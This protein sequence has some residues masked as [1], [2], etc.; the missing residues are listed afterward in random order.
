MKRIMAIVPTELLDSLER[1]LRHCGVPGVT[2]EHVQGY[3]HHPNY[4]RRD[5]L[6]N[7]VRIVLYTG[8]LRVADIIEALTR[9][10]QVSG[11][12]AGILS[13]DTVERLVS[14]AHGT[15]IDASSL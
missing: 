11:M 5:L 12:D 4:F 8:E 10:V 7:N 1:E 3:G 6:Q 2:V 13:V 9:C 15:D 14:L